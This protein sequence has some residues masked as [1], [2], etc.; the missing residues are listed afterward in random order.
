MRP[1]FLLRKRM[2]NYKKL[3]SFMALFSLSFN[4][5]GMEAIRN[6]AKT[7]TTDTGKTLEFV[8]NIDERTDQ[9]AD[10]MAARVPAIVENIIDQVRQEVGI[11]QQN[12][13]E[14]II[15]AIN[16]RII[17]ALAQNM[18]QQIGQHVGLDDEGEQQTLIDAL[19]EQVV[20]QIIENV[21]DQIEQ[22]IPVL[23]QNA[24]NSD[25]VNPVVNPII[26]NVADRLINR[27]N[28]RLPEVAQTLN[29]QIPGLVD[30][31]ADQVQ[32]HPDIVDPIIQHTRNNVRGDVHDMKQ[33]AFNL[34]F[35]ASAFGLIG[36]FVFPAIMSGLGLL[37]Q[38][39]KLGP[40]NKKIL[41]P[42]KRT[43][44]HVLRDSIVGLVAGIGVFA[45]AK[46]IQHAAAPTA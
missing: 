19:N 22:Q 20:P 24:L 43:Y 35:G 15:D 7:P 18:R 33:G 5:V 12:E 44:Y 3:F 29:D 40:L 34:I 10:R 13:D 38:K 9:I 1:S 28:E 6:W 36:S 16:A 8:A 45:L 21:R 26:D 17:P 30:A 25:V 32:Q 4:L 11:E 46:G 42:E 41:P 2:M 39:K 37:A 31:V 14:T 23:V 27:L